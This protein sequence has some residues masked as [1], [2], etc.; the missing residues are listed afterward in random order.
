M[1][2][3]GWVCQNWKLTEKPMNKISKKPPKIA[4][5]ML[6][7]MINRYTRYTALGD[8]E[9]E[10]GDD[11]KN[12]GYF[13][14]VLIYWS[15]LFA[16]L[17]GYIQ[18][19]LSVSGTMLNNYLKIACRNMSRN[20]VYSVINISGLAI[21]MTVFTLIIVFVL[22]EYSYDKFNEKI[23]RIYRVGFENFSQ[24]YLAPGIGK[25]IRENIPEVQKMARFK[26]RTDY[27]A[28]YLPE[29]DPDNPKYTTIRRFCWVDR[30]VFD[31]FS[32]EF[33]AGDPSEALS[34]P[35]SIVLT[36][37]IADILF[38]EENPLGKTIRINN[39]NIYTVT[40][41][42]SDPDKFHIDF[43]VLASFVTL[44]KII[45]EH[46]LN[47]YRSWNLQT[48]VLLPEIH[49]KTAVS[50]KMTEHFHKILKKR[51]I[52]DLYALKGL[53]F[54]GLGSG[55]Y[56]NLQFIYIFITAAFFI[57]LIACINYI[58]LSTAKAAKRAKEIG[59]RKVSGSLKRML[60]SQFLLESVL[61]SAISFLAAGILLILF[62]PIFNSM[63]NSKLSLASLNDPL[64]VIIIF[65]GVFIIGLI[66]G[67]YPALY[68]SG[69]KPVSVLKGDAAK[70]R[71]GV[72]FRRTL[73]V[74][75]FAISII[76]IIGTVVVF[77]QLHYVK[78]ADLGF[79][80]EQ[81]IHFDL[82]RELRSM[83]GV[84]RERLLRIPGIRDV[85]F[86]QGYPGRIYNWESFDHKGERTGFAV[87]SVDPEYFDIYDFELIDGRKFSR[88]IRS[89]EFGTCI[90]N[91]EAARQFKLVD[92]VG[93]VFYRSK[94]GSSSFPSK[95]VEVIGVVKD[96]HFES[97]QDEI[98]P[99]L[100]SWNEGWLWMANIRISPTGISETLENIRQLSIELAPDFPFEYS[101]INESFNS[102]Y[103]SEERFGSIFGYF[104]ILAVFI[105][106]LGL[107]GLALFIVEQRKKEVGIR[108]VL[109]S[110]LSGI[111]VLLSDEFTKWVISANIIAWPISWFII[112]R[113]L[114]NFAY[115]INIDLSVFILA[116]ILSVVIAVLTISIQTFRAASA[117]PVDSLRYE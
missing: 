112:D 88:N 90:M 113:W 61:I 83:R 16:V 19:K 53:Y 59:I 86:S 100:F 52:F 91:E 81:I 27:L 7:K 6:E 40:G 72:I 3:S 47:S 99:L 108:K 48:Y 115:R 2:R 60:V 10:Y 56:G 98:R 18:E 46:E 23:E 17:P 75:Q 21:G 32:F 50:N 77:Q 70:G 63:I 65:G 8:Y 15:H 106:C 84:F 14:A 103:K 44:G 4:R 45:G 109:G 38:S 31:I 95:E 51:N 68:L 117:N 35:Y 55:R 69:I 43:D 37:S 33:I 64:T 101:F 73:V 78:N 24:T 105:A 116:G 54:Q 89:D 39:T 107:F 110:S 49:D 22:N 74:V 11:L 111:I 57:L 12:K 96:F 62:I 30:D 114:N 9:E 104:S 85:S 79:N 67:L 34:V 71:K 28:K 29:R 87:F 58:N 42:I 25:E 41:V 13:I 20:R 97:L 82:N 5:W 92:P 102:Q 80:K 76:L 1:H 94:W 26:I 66:A 93:T 36:E